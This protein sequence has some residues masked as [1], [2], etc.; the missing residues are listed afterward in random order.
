MKRSAYQ[1]SVFR[2]YMVKSVKAVLIVAGWLP[3]SFEAT[4]IN[5]I[6][7]KKISNILPLIAKLDEAML[8]SITSTEMA[9]DLPRPGVAFD[10]RVMQDADGDGSSSG[11]VLFVSDMGLKRK[12][13][14]NSNGKDETTIL[15]RPKVLLEAAFTLRA[16]GVSQRV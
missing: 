8:E 3:E 14:N 12:D 4:Q 5:S 15:L 16:E 7:D 11:V 13:R 9:I 2:G 10:M 6:I 1:T